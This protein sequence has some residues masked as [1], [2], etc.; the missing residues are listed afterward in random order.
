[1]NL[2]LQL[3]PREDGGFNVHLSTAVPATC[4]DRRMV[5]LMINRNGSTCCASCAAK[6][7]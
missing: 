4:C 7:A 2:T 1:M 5:M 3:V 6:A